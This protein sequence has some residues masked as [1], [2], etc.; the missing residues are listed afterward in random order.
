MMISI[1][2]LCTDK[3][4]KKDNEKKMQKKNGMKWN[5]R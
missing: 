5:K 1:W 2:N 4:R 3:A